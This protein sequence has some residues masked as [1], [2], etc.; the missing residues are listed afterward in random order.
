MV[1]VTYTQAQLDAMVLSPTEPTDEILGG[2]TY[3]RRLQLQ[4]TVKTTN[5][6][7]IARIGDDIFATKAPTHQKSARCNFS[8]NLVQC[9]AKIPGAGA[10]GADKDI[11]P[12]TYIFL[13][14]NGIKTRWIFC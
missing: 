7:N 14:E 13:E 1:S 9:S 4:N 12:D 3:Q 2:G 10:G 5:Q 6:A 8:I 11:A